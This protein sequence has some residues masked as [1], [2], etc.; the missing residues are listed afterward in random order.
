MR[1]PLEDGHVTIVRAAAGVRFPA[2]FSLV[3]AMNPCPC[4]FAGDES[5]RCVC[6]TT[7]IQRYRSRLSGPLADRID[8]H[9][10]VTAMPLAELG[11][12]M[13]RES[14]GTV[15]GRVEA[16]RGVQRARYG[17][18][19]GDVWNG[20]VPG[21]WLDRSAG[22]AAES[23]TLLATAAERLGISA[24]GYHRV[25]RVART[26]ADLDGVSRIEPAHVAEALR[27]RPGDATDDAR[28]S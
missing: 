14:S 16:A 24:R 11:D 2:Q 10:N 4:G 21:R 9:V 22:L 26:I 19:R 13:A 12:G 3:G 20:T 25:L 17:R 28:V 8:L 6:A 18:M 23:R 15:R 5:G 1:Q 7:D 27:Y